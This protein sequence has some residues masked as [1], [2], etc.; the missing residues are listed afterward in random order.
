MT[1]PQRYQPL[2]DDLARVAVARRAGRIRSLVVAVVLATALVGLAALALMLGDRVVAPGDVLT[3]LLGGGSG[4]DRFVILGLRVPRLLL[5]LMVGAAFGLAGAVFQSLLGN[6]LAS[7][8][9]IGIT[10]GASAAAVGSILLL[11]WSGLAVSFAAFGGAVLVAGLITVLAA[12]HG[13]VGSRFVLIGIALAFLAQA[14]INFMLTRSDVRD[15][16]SA[17]VW[18]VGS[19]GTVTSEEL[20][21]TAVGLV[22]LAVALAVVS[23]WLRM[24]QL[25]DEAATG[26]GVRVTPAR[27]VITLIAVGL[28][29]VATAAAGPVVFVAFVSAPI[30]RR[31]LGGTGPALVVSALVGALVVTGSDLIAQHAVSGLQVPVGIVTGIVGAPVLLILLARSNRSRGTA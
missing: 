13:V 26:L 8:D 10:Q 18:L 28:A 21:G 31:L 29:A 23:P 17:L 24:L 4:G 22:V 30:A 12:R 11:G 19:L 14:A 16:Q 5:G 7:P 15:A 2:L 20:T 25:G 6:P 27:L 9:I 3:T 1:V